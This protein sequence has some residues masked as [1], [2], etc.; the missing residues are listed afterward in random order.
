VRNCR[1][2]RGKDQQRCVH[3]AA[4]YLCRNRQRARRKLDSHP[5][6]LRLYVLAAPG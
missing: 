1:F 4:R 5:W 2:L 6:C 3:A